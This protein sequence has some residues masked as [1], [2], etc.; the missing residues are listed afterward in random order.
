MQK[1][2]SDMRRSIVVR[3]FDRLEEC[4]G[5]EACG[6]VRQNSS[7]SLHDVDELLAFRSDG[8]LEELR[9][10]LARIENGTFGLCLACRGRIE[11]RL[12]DRDPAQRLCGHCERRL[13]HVS[14]SRSPVVQYLAL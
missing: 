9:E 6:E 3:I 11:H 4:Y 7:L 1:G 8:R 13:F 10:A 14:E 5:R 2:W 12:L